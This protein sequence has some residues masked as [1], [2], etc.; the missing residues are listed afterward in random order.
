MMWLRMAALMHVLVAETQ[1]GNS[2]RDETDKVFY[3][4]AIMLQRN[5][6]L[7]PEACTKRK[8]VRSRLPLFDA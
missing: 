5:N 3:L 8:S 4:C 6:Q 7:F 1:R 2:V